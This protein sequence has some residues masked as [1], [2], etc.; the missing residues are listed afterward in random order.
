MHSSQ[1]LRLYRLK[2]S[3]NVQIL[4]RENR[5]GL[6]QLFLYRDYRNGDDLSIKK[7]EE[8]VKDER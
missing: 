4:F 1:G 6:Q 8:G 2:P 5:N 3:Q 7:E